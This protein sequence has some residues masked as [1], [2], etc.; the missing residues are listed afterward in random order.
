MSEQQLRDLYINEIQILKRIEHPAIVKLY[1]MLKSSNNFYIIYEYITQPSIL[2]LVNNQYFNNNN[3]N[4]IIQLNTFL[5][6]LL[7]T[8]LYL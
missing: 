4:N 2:T 3:N 7:D 8:L 1:K 6:S 5:L